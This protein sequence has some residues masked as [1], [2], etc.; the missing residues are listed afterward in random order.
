[1]CVCMQKVVYQMEIMMHVWSH[2]LLSFHT[3]LTQKRRS[4]RVE[5]SFGMQV[6]CIRQT[7]CVLN[8]REWEKKKRGKRT[9]S[10]FSLSTFLTVRRISGTLGASAF[11]IRIDKCFHL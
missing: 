4:L 11:F 8:A 3:S 10:E 9:K 2:N 5:Q 7:V 1:M 6:V